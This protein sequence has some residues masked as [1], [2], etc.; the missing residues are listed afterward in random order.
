ML[1]VGEEGGCQTSYLKG[2]TAA[3]G[4]RGSHVNT[5]YTG[6]FIILLQNGK[7]MPHRSFPYQ[8]INADWM[9]AQPGK[10][11]R[12]IVSSPNVSMV[13]VL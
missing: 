2:S 11:K 3:D 7:N 8:P 9:I 13:T 6:L 12:D 1:R 4:H 5:E 10:K